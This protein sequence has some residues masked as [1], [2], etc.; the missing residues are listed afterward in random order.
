MK[1]LLIVAVIIAVGST[2]INKYVSP[3]TQQNIKEA[4]AL[5]YFPKPE[6]HFEGKV[7]KVY[8]E[9]VYFGLSHNKYIEVNNN[10]IEV[11]LESKWQ[12]GQKV[13]YYPGNN[14]KVF[15]IN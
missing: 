3:S 13:K 4:A 14:P 6:E 2:L 10:K 9:S 5:P 7:E 1:K 15:K 12:N 11:P 8:T